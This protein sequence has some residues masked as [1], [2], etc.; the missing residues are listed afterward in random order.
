MNELMNSE[1]KEIAD[2]EDGVQDKKRKKKNKSGGGVDVKK[3]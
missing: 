2:G 3:K 1:S